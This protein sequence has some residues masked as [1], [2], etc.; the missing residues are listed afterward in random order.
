MVAI[1]KGTSLLHNDPYVP[2]S[3]EEDSDV[4]QAVR[5]M[6]F[7]CYRYSIDFKQLISGVYWNIVFLE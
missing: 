1:I 3:F 6:L 5:E 7:V 2:F 4:F